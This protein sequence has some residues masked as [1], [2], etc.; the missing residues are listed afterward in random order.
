MAYKDL[1]AT[2]G[3]AEPGAPQANPARGSGP[4]RWLGSAWAAATGRYSIAAV[5]LA[6]LLGLVGLPTLFV[7]L[8]AV[9]R[10]PLRLGEGF[11]FTTLASV[12]TSRDVLT[13]LWQTVAV[14]LVVGLAATALGA[15]MAWVLARFEWPRRGLLETI[16]V[17]PLFLSPLVGTIAW[18]ALAAPRS[19]ILDYLLTQIGAPGFLHLNVDSVWGII[20]VL[21][22]NYA[23][24]GY[25]FS[26]GVLR[27]MDPSLEEAAYM[28]G[29]GIAATAR[30]IVVPLLRTGLLSS[31]LFI[32]IL[33]AGEFSV[34]S[35]LGASSSYVPL[36]VQ[37]Y[38]AVYNFPQNYPRAG[39]ISTMMVVLSLIA[40]FFYRRATR[41]SQRF[42]TVTGK[43]FAARRMS[44]GSWR[45]PILGFLGIYIFVT[46]VLP[47]ASLLLIVFTKYRTGDLADLHFT[48]QNISNVL[49]APDVRSAI[50]NTVEI[51]V[52]VPICCV[53][54]G[55]IVVY[56]TDRARI[57]GGG[58]ANYLA[59][60]PL[61][62]SGI[63]FG[64]GV[65]VAY[66]R[67]PLYATIWL[68]A[69][70]LIAH[71]ISHAVRIIGNGFS[72]LD[73]SLEEAAHLNGASRSMVLRTIDA[74]LLRPSLIS[75]FMLIYVFTVREVNTAIVLYSPTSLVLS[76]LAWNYLSDGTFAQAAVVGVIQTVLMIVGIVVARFAFGIRA[77]RSA[78]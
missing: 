24:Y 17:I 65:F 26:S 41:G 6:V 72:Q 42:V 25:L 30:R 61:A 3:I 70:A 67:S 36:S 75:A 59:T 44:P 14:S 2:A 40:L 28:C 1:T 49:N 73:S 71:Y 27:N 51:S 12:Y 9:A 16:M 10:N 31:I 69:V 54:V 21:T 62:I 55:I 78:L 34:P 77:T 8:T 63:V 11:S 52:V 53:L 68:I 48:L 22:I 32:S 43:G 20:G 5:V 19:G 18:Q 39:A 47:Y 74:P 35:I 50:L 38:D 64:T 46:I 29:S 15:I 58:F 37:V 57:P 7:L 66:I 60:A 56:C 23:P 33:A 4:G 13:S 45:R 76:V